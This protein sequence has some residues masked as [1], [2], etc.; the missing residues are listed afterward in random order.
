M[1]VFAGCATPEGESGVHKVTVPADQVQPHDMRFVDQNTKAADVLEDAY[2][3]CVA[4]LS[5]CNSDKARIREFNRE[6]VE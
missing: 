1:S 2:P 4:E 5:Q 3:T 6:A